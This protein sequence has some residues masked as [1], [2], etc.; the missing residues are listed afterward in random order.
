MQHIEYRHFNIIF[1]IFFWGGGAKFNF[2]PG[3]QLP[4][5]RHWSSTY[6]FTDLSTRRINLTNSL[7]NVSECP[8]FSASLDL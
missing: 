5:L 4:S 6:S 2:A 7:Q 1:E 3:R 8:I